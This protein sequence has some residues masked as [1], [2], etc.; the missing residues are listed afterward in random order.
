MAG[1]RVVGI[2]QLLLAVAGF[3]MFVG[4]FALRMLQLYNEVVNGVEP[5]SV[6]WLAQAGVGTFAAG[7]LWGL[8]TSVR[9]L[10]EGRGSQSATAAEPGA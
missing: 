10:R 5:K 2:G 9:I 6:A 8:M 7:W 3:G 4:W 1:R